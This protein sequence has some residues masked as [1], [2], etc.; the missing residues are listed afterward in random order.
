MFR[1]RL[2]DVLYHGSRLKG[3]FLI[4]EQQ[5]PFLGRARF[6]FVDYMTVD[7][8][9]QDQKHVNL[10]PLVPPTHKMP[11][12]A[13]STRRPLRPSQYTSKSCA[14]ERSKLQKQP[15]NCIVTALIFPGVYF[16]E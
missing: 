5:K 11:T 16:Y 13:K 14:I 10:T 4:S 15:F 12:R 2:A 8:N 3:S 6:E 1:V 7:K 9:K